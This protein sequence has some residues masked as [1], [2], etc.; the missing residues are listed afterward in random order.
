MANVSN[1]HLNDKDIRA[2][3]PKNTRYTKAVGDPKELYVFVNPKGTKKFSL[4][5]K[6]DDKSHWYE[7]NEFRE[8]IYSVAEARKDALQKLKDLQRADGNIEILKDGNEKYSFGN[9]FNIFIEQKQMIGLKHSYLSKIQQKCG[10]YLLPSLKHKDVKDVKYSDLLNILKPIYNPNNPNVNRLETIYCLIRYLHSIFKPA[11]KDGYLEKDPSL[12]LSDE[13]PSKASFNK[14]HEL[15]T[16]RPALTKDEDL[17]EFIKDLKND[18]KI[19]LQTKRAI[20]LHILSANRPFN[21][22]S[23]KWEYIDFE[24]GLWTIPAKDMKMGLIH[25]VPLTK[26]MIKILKEQRL[27]SGDLSEFVFPTKSKKGHLNIESMGKA[28][29]NLGGKGK[30]K[31]KVVSHGFRATFRTICTQN[32]A[33]ILRL[34]ISEDTIESALAHKEQNMIV[35]AYEREKATIEQKRTLL[36]WYED[37]LKGIEDLG[38]N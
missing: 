11:L 30:W 1:T 36:Q 32:K 17:R 13:F 31:G 5:I 19:Q 34:G 9:L 38:I 28:I 10:K 6:R 24:K 15:D 18:N 8:G 35:F 29:K 12:Y 14:R 16:R 22:V 7:L 2:L 27:F 21:T 26:L 4:R 23:V 3:K 25:Q 37:Y 33:E 20:Y